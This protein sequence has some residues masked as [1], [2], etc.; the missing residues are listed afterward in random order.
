MAACLGLVLI[1]KPEAAINYSVAPITALIEEANMTF[2]QSGEVMVASAEDT[3][4]CP[5]E[6]A[7]FSYFN[8]GLGDETADC[9]A[10]RWAD[11]KEAQSRG[12]FPMPY[13][14]WFATDESEPIPEVEIFRIH[15]GDYELF[16]IVDM[17]DEHA[18]EGPV[19]FQSGVAYRLWES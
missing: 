9:T 8:H 1:P 14:Q 19:G 10:L 2:P 12:I 17:L 3:Y 5:T 13:A 11:V 18:L 7:I 6:D 16:A 4:A 15:Y